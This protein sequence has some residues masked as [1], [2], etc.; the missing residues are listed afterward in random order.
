MFP[1]VAARGASQIILNVTTPALLFS[2]IVPA[3][4]TDNIRVF[5]TWPGC[6]FRLSRSHSRCTGPLLLVSIT[7]EILGIALAW[8]VKQFFWVPHRFR[9]GILVAGGWNNV[10]DIRTL[11][12]PIPSRAQPS[13]NGFPFLQ[14]YLWS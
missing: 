7:Y 5:G 9:H 2:K 1:P 8:L 4:N 11:P 10:G 12:Q 14:Q 6:L 3:F 13:D